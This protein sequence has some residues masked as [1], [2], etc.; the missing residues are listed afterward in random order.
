MPRAAHVIEQGE[1]GR[2]V[3]SIALKELRLSR[4]FFSSLKFKNGILLDGAPAHADRRVRAG[5]TLEAVW[6]DENGFSYEEPCTVS[7][8]IPYE[9]EWYMIVEKPAPLP[10]LSSAKQSG[11]TLENALYAHLGCPHNYVFRPVNRLDK[12]TS[13]LMAIAKDAHAQQLLQRQLHTDAFIREY[14]AICEGQLPRK[15]GVIRAP[16]GKLDGIRR[17]VTENGTA[18]VTRYRVE[19]EK[20]SLSLVRLRLETGRTHQI[21]VHLAYLGCPVAGDYLY[22]HK[23]ARLPERFALHAC[24]LSFLHPLTGRTVCAQS[25]LPSSLQA[26]WEHG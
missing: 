25:A 18:A 21:R 2:T 20:E 22:G 7:F 14:L 3:K 13:G 24:A 12:G 8:S 17:G 11:P 19:A 23:D 6:E 26:I 4:G 1:E 9:D 16:I 10:T 5:Q 15:E